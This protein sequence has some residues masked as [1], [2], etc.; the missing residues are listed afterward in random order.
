[1]KYAAGL[2]HVDTGT[3]CCR[4]TDHRRGSRIVNIEVSCS[5]LE[6]IGR[7]YFITVAIVRLLNSDL[8]L[9]KADGITGNGSCG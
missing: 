6:G 2:A 7:V 8:H 4:Y 1:M 9:L 5:E 3:G